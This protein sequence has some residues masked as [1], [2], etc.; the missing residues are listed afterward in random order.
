MEAL[1]N[2]HDSIDSQWRE[3]LW[4]NSPPNG[5]VATGTRLSSKIGR[6]SIRAANVWISRKRPS[7]PL[8][9]S[10][11]SPQAPSTL[12]IKVNT[13]ATHSQSQKT[14]SPF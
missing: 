4:E 5:G 8:V 9:A 6:I 1:N 11:D 13:T 7:L 2:E 3:P 14:N 10:F 12:A